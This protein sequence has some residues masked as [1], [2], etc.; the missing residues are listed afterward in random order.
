MTA[1]PTVKRF[2]LTGV[3]ADFRAGA[4]VKTF[5][6][7]WRCRSELQWMDVMPELATGELP[8]I[9][10]YEQRSGHLPR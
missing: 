8:A 2:M 3:L 5:Y 1:A 7:S 10:K 4:Q 6:P 9:Y